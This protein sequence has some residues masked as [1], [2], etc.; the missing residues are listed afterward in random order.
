LD[1]RQYILM[2]AHSVLYAWALPE[3]VLAGNKP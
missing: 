1:G 3:T 2:G